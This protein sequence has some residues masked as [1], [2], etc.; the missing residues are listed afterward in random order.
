VQRSTCRGICT[1]GP[2]QAPVPPND[3]LSQ[4][5]IERTSADIDPSPE[6][7]RNEPHDGP[8]VVVYYRDEAEVRD[9][10]LIALRAMGLAGVEQDSEPAT[11]S[12]RERKTVKTRYFPYL[13]PI[14]MLLFACGPTASRGPTDAITFDTA[15]RLDDFVFSLGRRQAAPMAGH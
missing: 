9:G 6:P 12:C 13:L 10:F 7:C 4:S 2:K 5:A 14:C 8:S 1:H 11:P 15:K 3:F